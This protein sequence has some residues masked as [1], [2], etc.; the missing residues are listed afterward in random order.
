MTKRI[1]GFESSFAI[2][3]ILAVATVYLK[4]NQN[5]KKIHGISRE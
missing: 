4:V 3:A 5:F 2:A 1:P